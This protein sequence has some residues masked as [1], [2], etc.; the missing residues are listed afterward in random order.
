MKNLQADYLYADLTYKIIGIAMSIHTELGPVHKEI[1]YHNALKKEFILQHIPF[2][3]EKI[4]PV[5]YKGEQVGT[6]KPD[7]VIDDKVVVEIKA[8]NFLPQSSEAQLS[9]YIKGSGYKIG[10]LFNFGEKHLQ[11]KRRIYDRVI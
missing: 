3:S 5:K 11:V 7:F 6:Y 10:L 2:A 4:I 8:L 9:Y 1:V